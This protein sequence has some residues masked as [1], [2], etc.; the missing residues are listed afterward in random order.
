MAAKLEIPHEEDQASE[1]PRP[2]KIIARS[3]FAE[4]T[5]VVT[6]DAKTH[7]SSRKSL[8]DAI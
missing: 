3:S 2:R 6:I 8:R 7:R 5:K 4:A 1:I